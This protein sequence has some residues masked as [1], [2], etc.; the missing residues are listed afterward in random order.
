MRRTLRTAASTHLSLLNKSGHWLR[1]CTW[2]VPPSHRTPQPQAGRRPWWSGQKASDSVR[3]M[4]VAPLRPVEPLVT[5]GV[6]LSHRR[7]NHH[8]SH[9]AVVPVRGGRGVRRHLQHHHHHHINAS[10]PP[11]VADTE[12]PDICA[13][14][15][16]PVQV[17]QVKKAP[18]P[19]S[20]DV[21]LL[22]LL[23]QLPV[24]RPPSIG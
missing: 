3:Y 6:V 9:L 16:S 17:V 8:P 11:R 13:A 2:Y 24:Q 18:V 5:G 10:A 21:D 14:L 1:Q 20:L 4:P 12:R 7:R 23:Q 19:A 22:L 15:P